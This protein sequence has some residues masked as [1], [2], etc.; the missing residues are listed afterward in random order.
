MEAVEY[1]RMAALH[2]Q[3]WLGPGSTVYLSLGKAKRQ[4]LFSMKIVYGKL[5]FWRTLPG[6]IIAHWAA[7]GF[8]IATFDFGLCSLYELLLFRC[9]PSTFSNFSYHVL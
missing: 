8:G 4:R 7:I 9:K 1:N 5:R 2:A 6:P 3:R